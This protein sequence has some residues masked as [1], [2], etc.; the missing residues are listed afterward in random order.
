MEKYHK[1]QLISFEGF[2]KRS[3]CGRSPCSS[4]RE[5]QARQGGGARLGSSRIHLRLLRVGGGAP[6]QVAGP[7]GA[8][9]D[10][11]GAPAG[12][13]VLGV[14]R[15]LLAEGGRPAPLRPPWGLGGLLRGLRY[16]IQPSRKLPFLLPAGRCVI[17]VPA[18]SMTRG[19]GGHQDMGLGGRQDTGPGGHQGGHQACLGPIGS[20]FFLV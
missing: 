18:G 3:T 4:G 9:P 14:R 20:F 13:H 5:V 15:R 12:R 6:G 8:Q 2:P 16:S 19:A 7:G 11:E 10:G 17:W 1:K